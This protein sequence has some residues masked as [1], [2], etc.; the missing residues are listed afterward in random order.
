M[1]NL[2]TALAFVVLLGGGIFLD[3]LVVNAVCSLF[4]A[5][6]GAGLIAM[7]IALWIILSVLTGGFIFAAAF[8]FAGAI[9]TSVS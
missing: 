1:K 4:P 3:S 7:Q 6:V 2:L 5:I 8:I 9:R